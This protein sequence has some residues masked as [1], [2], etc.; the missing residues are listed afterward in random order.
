[1]VISTFRHWWNALAKKN[2]KLKFRNE[3]EAA[4][5]VRRIQNKNRGPNAKLIEMRKEYEAVKKS[6][7]EGRAA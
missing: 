3:R 7:T 1:M 6:Q 5:F 2:G 4:D